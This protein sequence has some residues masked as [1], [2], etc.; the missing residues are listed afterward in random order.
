MTDCK[1]GKN[2]ISWCNG[3]TKSGP[4]NHKCLYVI[5]TGIDAKILGKDNAFVFENETNA[6]QISSIFKQRII[7]IMRKEDAVT[8]CLLFKTISPEVQE[9]WKLDKHLITQ[10]IAKYSKKLKKNNE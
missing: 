4:A 2:C 1:C 5:T 10:S 7:A 9:F 6:K 3:A 8:H